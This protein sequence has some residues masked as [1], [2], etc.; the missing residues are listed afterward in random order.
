M[1]FGCERINAGIDTDIANEKIGTLDKM[2]Y[3]SSDRLQKQHVV[4]A[5]VVLRLTGQ[6]HAMKFTADRPWS[7]P[8][9]AARKLLE[10]ANSVE[11]VQDGRIY[12]ELINGPFLFRERATPAEYSAGLKLAIERGW[13]MLHDSGTYLKFTQAGADLFA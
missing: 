13:L 8:E 10:I 5:M 1:I 3:L 6:G 2:R 12:I 9:K 11:V 7:D 4:V